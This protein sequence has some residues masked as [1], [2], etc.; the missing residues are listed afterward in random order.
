VGESGRTYCATFHKGCLYIATSEY[1]GKTNKRVP[2][3]FYAIVD[4]SARLCDPHIDRW[5]MVASEDK[6]ALAFPAIAARREG[7]V[8]AFTLGSDDTITLD[9]ETS[10]A[11]AG[12]RNSHTERVGHSEE[13][14]IASSK[15]KHAL[16]PT[17]HPTQ[18]PVPASLGCSDILCMRWEA[19][20]NA[21][22]PARSHQVTRPC[23]STTL[24]MMVPWVWF[25]HSAMLGIADLTWLSCRPHSKSHDVHCKS[26]Y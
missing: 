1:F 8:L 5:G 2:S 18:R 22:W 26:S 10:P 15:V 9:G 6:Y 17:S 23:G 21:P 16:G 14:R 25:D 11:Y 24:V 7:V 20:S 3:I 13:F 12:E 4:P 19:C